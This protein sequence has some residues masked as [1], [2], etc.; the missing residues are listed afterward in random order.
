L[1][2]DPQDPTQLYLATTDGLFV[3]HDGGVGWQQTTQLGLGTG[4]IRHLILHAPSP[5]AAYAA[6]PQGVARYDP[7][8]GRW[9]A[10]YAGLPTQAVHFLAA[11]ESKIF[12]ATDQG[13]YALDLTDEQLA[14]GNWPSA[15]EILGNF[16][17]EPLIGQVQETAVRYAEVHPDKIKRWRRRAALQALLPSLD[18]DV[19]RNKSLDDTIDEGSFPNY[20]L[21]PS[22]D[23]DRNMTVT[24]EWD[25]GELIWNPNQTS[26][27]E[28]SKLM[29]Q[30]RDDILDEVTRAFFERRRVQ[31]ELLTDLPSNPKKQLDKELR[32]AEL[33]AMLD[34]FTGGWFSD[35][36][37]LNGDR[38]R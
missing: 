1:A 15:R 17:H 16:V 25:L 9:E 19:Y 23:I 26:I 10:L 8:N 27:D 11:T 35:Q 31:I 4:E 20:Q 18:F 28:R 21:I 13:L 22:R 2:I 6:T 34:G 33:T 24:I 5:V 14:Q 37:E 30:L 36:L 12:A 29:V 38:L 32:L 3:S 7:T